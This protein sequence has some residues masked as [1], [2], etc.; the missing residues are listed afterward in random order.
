MLPFDAPKNIEKSKGK[1]GKNWNNDLA[2]VI[3]IEE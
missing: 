3:S 2:A 1:I